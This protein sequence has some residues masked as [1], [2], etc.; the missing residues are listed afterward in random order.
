MYAGI[1]AF[2]KM[3]HGVGS[4]LQVID[5]DDL[6]GY[7][8]SVSDDPERHSVAAVAWSSSEKPKRLTVDPAARVFDLMGN[9]IAERT[10]ELTETP[11]YLKAFEPEPVLR[12]L[13]KSAKRAD[14]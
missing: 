3:F 13:T 11:V 1:A 14:Q 7:V 5:R 12:T 6:H 4:P 2:T 10:F 9:P 8:F